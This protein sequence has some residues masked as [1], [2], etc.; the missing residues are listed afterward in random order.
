MNIDKIKNILRIVE[1]T[2]QSDNKKNFRVTIESN[3]R[4]HFMFP[5][6]RIDVYNDEL[7]LGEEIK[8]EYTIPLN[9]IVTI[10]LFFQEEFIRLD[11]RIKG[12][13]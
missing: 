8:S 1:E 12:E 2:I 13:Y 7:H 9:Q 11:L 6:D 4:I 5:A 3:S 10:G